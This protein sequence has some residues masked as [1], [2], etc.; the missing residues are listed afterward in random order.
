MNKI[1]PYLYSEHW[2]KAGW[3]FHFTLPDGDKNIYIS[4]RI[5]SVITMVL[6]TA[7]SFFWCSRTKLEIQNLWGQILTREETGSVAGMYTL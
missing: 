6:L 5:D 7:T 2:C 1:L 4:W 3:L